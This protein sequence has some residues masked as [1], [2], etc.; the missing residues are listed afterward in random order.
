LDPTS[1]HAYA[2]SRRRQLSVNLHVCVRLRS[3]SRL[4]VLMLIWFRSEHQPSDDIPIDAGQLQGTIVSSDLV[5]G[6]VFSRRMRGLLLVGGRWRQSCNV[7]RNARRVAVYTTM[8]PGKGS[9]VQLVLKYSPRQFVTAQELCTAPGNDARWHWHA[10]S[11]CTPAARSL[12]MVAD[13][14]EYLLRAAFCY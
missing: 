8:H 12:A 9:V 1:N 3:M 7:A 5:F 4:Y 2:R 11:L 6:G 10:R 14:T 13:S